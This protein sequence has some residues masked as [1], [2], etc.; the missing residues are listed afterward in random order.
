MS[1]F[2]DTLVWGIVCPIVGF[3]LYLTEMLRVSSEEEYYALH[4]KSKRWFIMIWLPA[5]IMH[6]VQCT[7]YA[8]FKAALSPTE[9][10]SIIGQLSA[11]HAG[12]IIWAFITPVL[13]TFGCF[14]AHWFF[15]FAPRRLQAKAQAAVEGYLP[16]DAPVPLAV[17]ERLVASLP[18]VV[19]DQRPEV[20]DF[21]YRAAL[22]IV[23]D[24]EEFGDTF[25]DFL[26]GMA[27]TE[28]SSLVYYDGVVG[29]S[30]IQRATTRVADRLEEEDLA[31]EKE[32]AAYGLNFVYRVDGLRADRKRF[33][34]AV[35]SIS[36]R[37]ARAHLEREHAA[38]KAKADKAIAALEDTQAQLRSTHKKKLIRL[39]TKEL[40]DGKH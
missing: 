27:F 38:L 24:S 40:T 20:F 26:I 11:E 33:L 6:S 16:V 9:A 13:A 30:L 36:T 18:P 22:L 12:I 4:P 19:Q 35:S 10:Q 25:R 17:K 32:E 23:G 3:L 14:V 34:S 28:L 5:I 37:W 29:Y 21:C 1:I 31:E 2:M 15:M 8:S 7:D 39:T